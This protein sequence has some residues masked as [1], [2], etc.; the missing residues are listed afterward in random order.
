[1]RSMIGD[2]LG[3]VLEPGGRSSVRIGKYLA[4]SL[5]VVLFFWMG[6]A[7]AAS[8][9]AKQSGTSAKEKAAKK[10]CITGDVKTGIDILGDLYVDTAD[11]TYVFNQGRCYE[12]NHLWVDA[13][14][15]FREYLRKIPA[16]SEKE[17]ADA[18]AHVADCEALIA[19]H[20]G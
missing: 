8:S 9:R 14:D 4:V 17:K 10:A 18:S 5:G 13:I 7:E 20:S 12:Q 2:S 19:K 16:G 11:V 15:R 6:P 3:A 1:M